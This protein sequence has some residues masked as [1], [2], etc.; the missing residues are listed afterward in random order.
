MGKDEPV[1]VARPPLL[2][3]KESPRAAPGPR[4][5]REGST[6]FFRAEVALDDAQTGSKWWVIE[7]GDMKHGTGEV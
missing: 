6:F 4:C 2:Y 1:Y 3:E 5:C 7:E